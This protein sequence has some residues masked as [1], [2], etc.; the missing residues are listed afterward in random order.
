[1]PD[2]GGSGDVLRLKDSWTKGGKYRETLIPYQMQ[3]DAA[4]RKQKAIIGNG[5]LIPRMSYRDQL[6]RFR[7]AVRIGGIH[8]C[9]GCVT[10]TAGPSISI[11]LGLRPAAGGPI[12]KQLTPEQNC[13]SQ[14]NDA[15]PSRSRWDITS[16]QITAVYLG[17]FMKTKTKIK[18]STKKAKMDKKCR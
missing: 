3:K 12:V 2:V 7:S 18:A 17:S 15:K 1:M 11:S 5:S 14:R 9:M 8:P 16:I 6:N 10:S 13:R 4:C